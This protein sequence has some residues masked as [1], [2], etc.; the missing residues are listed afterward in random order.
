MFGLLRLGAALWMALAAS[1]AAA[2]ERGVL[3]ELFTSQ[4][5]S[6]CPPADRLLGELAARDDVIALSLHVDYWD[7]IGWADSFAQPRF[8]ARQKA[9]ARAAHSR[10]IFT[11]QI[12]VDGEDRIMGA[13]AMTVMDRIRAHAEAPRPVSLSLRREGG[14]LFVTVS[15]ERPVGP[16]VIQLVRYRPSATV[17]ITRGENAGRTAEYHNI[18]TTWR[19]LARWDGAAPL[20]LATEIEGERPVVVIVQS[21][22]HGPVLA[23]AR[24]R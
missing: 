8:T 9:Y 12:I 11:P 23:A 17:H 3:V 10:S 13:K 24:L 4:G 18:A 15:A 5:C 14:R 2:G 6:A 20:R 22:R 7:Y 21:E 1:V 16:A 19:A